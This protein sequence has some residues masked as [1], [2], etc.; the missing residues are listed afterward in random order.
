MKKRVFICSACIFP[1][2]SASANYIQYL[3]LALIENNCEVIVISFGD[4]K[5]CEYNED[6][7]RYYYKSIIFEKIDIRSSQPGHWLDY[8]YRLGRIMTGILDKYNPAPQDIIIAYS[9][10][11]TILEPLLRYAKQRGI[12]A[13]ACI[14]EWY[15]ASHFK[16]DIFGLKYKAYVNIFEKLLPQYDLVVPVST[17][18][19]SYLKTLGCST[20]ILPTM[21]D[22]FASMDEERGQD[23]IIRYLYIAGRGMKDSFE[24]AVKAFELLPEEMLEKL[25]LYIKNVTEDRLKN[26]LSPGMHK[27]IGSRIKCPGW[28]E[29]EELISLYKKTDFLIMAREVNRMTL[30]NFPSKIPEVMS[31]GMIPVVSEAGDYTRY[32]LTDGYD[33]II[34]RECTTECFL[35]AIMESLNLDDAARKEMSA[36]AL[37]TAR[38]KFNYRV[39]KDRINN[40]FLKE[41]Y[42]GSYEANSLYYGKENTT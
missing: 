31:Y 23:G 25:E 21:A 20:F 2:G 27:Y 8:R 19:D 5:S 33:S 40:A 12:W 24:T 26:I 34:A 35:N 11:K 10:R 6:E 3:A 17:H 9:S 42:G 22:P 1:R 36:R 16:P 29:Y 18:L 38:E 14:G 28:M 4:R 7:D 30:S 37:Q 39:W 32:Y 41:T 13:A 15:T